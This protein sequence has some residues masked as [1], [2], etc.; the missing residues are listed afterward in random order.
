MIESK[1]IKP[2]IGDDYRR[3][4]TMAHAGWWGTGIFAVLRAFE[5]IPVSMGSFGLLTL[6]V[7][8]TAS[9]ALSR[10]R[11]AETISGVFQVGL[12]SAI[13]LSANV[14]TDTCIMAIDAQGRVESVDHADAIGWDGA[15][16]VGRE[17]RTLLTPRSHGVRVFRAGTS[18]TSPM[19]NQGGETFDARLSFAAL[20]LSDEGESMIVT[21]SPVVSINSEGNYRAPNSNILN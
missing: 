6:G 4:I 5:V 13:A 14:F 1:W 15:S 12:Q 21:V 20:Q 11:L 10:M 17:L 8:V 16:L 2:I 9:L 7:G 3:T 18:M 19:L